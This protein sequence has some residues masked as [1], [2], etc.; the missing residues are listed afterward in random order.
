MRAVRFPV[1]LAVCLLGLPGAVMADPRNL[2]HAEVPG[3][4]A[5]ARDLQQSFFWLDSAPV[6]RQVYAAFRKRFNLAEVPSA[7]TLHLFADSRYHLWIN[8]Q[9]VDRG[10][11][12]FDPVAPEYDTLDVR[13][14]LKQG[15]NVVVVLVHH[16]H[17]GKE[18]TDWVSI[19][20]RIMRHA[21]GLTAR[22][23]STFADGRTEVFGPT[24]TWRGNTHTR[25]L[26]FTDRPL[27]E[28]LGEHSRPHRRTA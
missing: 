19:N 7:A 11:C 15:A 8:G 18:S 1:G 24:E 20:G 16:Y 26:P 17:D 28:H 5:V 22:L 14:W 23:E 9:Y 13:P 21:P 4:D 12:R 27:G 10:P 2:A 25:F 6:G 3:R